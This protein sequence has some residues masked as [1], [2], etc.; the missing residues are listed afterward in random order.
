MLKMTFKALHR[1]T[2]QIIESYKL[3]YSKLTPIT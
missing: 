2:F 1:L 3:V